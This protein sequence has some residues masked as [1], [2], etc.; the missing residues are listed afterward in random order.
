MSN[1]HESKFTYPPNFFD[2]KLP[3]G[4]MSPSQFDMYR[5][6]PKQYMYRYIEERTDPPGI[7]AAKGR[8]VHKGA[9]VTHQHTIDHGSPLALEDG[10]QVVADHYDG[11]LE[12]IE[13]LEGNDPGQLKD[14]T[15]Y[16]FQAYYT[17]AVPTIRPVK[18]EHAFAQ[19]VGI[20]P[21]RGLID[22]VDKVPAE[23][24][25]L[26]VDDDPENPPLLEVV[27]DLKVV[28]AKWSAQKVRHAPQLTIYAL[29]ENQRNIRVDLLLDQKTGIR[30]AP[31]RAERTAT[32]KRIVIEDVEEA[33]YNIKEGTF[34]RCDPTAWVCT[35]NWCGYYERCRGPK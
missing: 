14:R 18:V 15:L 21:M 24:D 5:R 11:E 25:D 8:S 3:K 19:K 22:L 32:D 16:C 34:P 31:Q 2:P 29:V 26:T 9:E 35:P 7:A 4:V 17:Q 6:C 12:D 30:Y 10:I 1:D 28:K 23:L 13:D 33:A 27:S 20:V